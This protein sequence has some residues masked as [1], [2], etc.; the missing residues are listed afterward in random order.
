MFVIV[1]R[2]VVHI[3]LS[4]GFVFR[5][6]NYEKVFFLLSFL[7]KKIR[8]SDFLCFC[9]PVPVKNNTENGG[10]TEGDWKVKTMPMNDKTMTWF[11]LTM[12]LIDKTTSLF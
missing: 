11:Y 3:V 2:V 4:F 9:R 10:K 5:V 12:P 8:E 6:Q 1:R 7:W